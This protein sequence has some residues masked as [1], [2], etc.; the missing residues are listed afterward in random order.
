MSVMTKKNFCKSA[1]VRSLNR[2]RVVRK[3]RKASQKA[4]KLRTKHLSSYCHGV[5][6]KSDKKFCKTAKKLSA[7]RLRYDNRV[8]KTMLR[9]ARARRSALLKHC[10]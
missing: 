8:T 2:P 10:K 3:F 5:T 6:T 9:R 4:H 7:R 1:K